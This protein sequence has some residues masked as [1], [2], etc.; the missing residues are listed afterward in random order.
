MNPL[1]VIVRNL[2]RRLWR[3]VRDESPTERSRRWHGKAVHIMDGAIASLDCR[4]EGDNVLHPGAGLSNV[5]LGRRTYVAGGALIRDTTIGR[6][7]SIG[8]HVSIVLGRH[9]VDRNVSTYPAFFSLDDRGCMCSFVE[10]TRFEEIRGVRI[11][12]DVWVGARALIIDGCSIGDGAVIAAGAVVTKDVAPYAVVGGVPARILRMRFPEHL[13]KKLLALKWW[14]KDEDWI[15]QHAA[16]F[17]DVEGLLD[18]A[19]SATQPREALP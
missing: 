14:D 18:V 15:R 13:V 3:A 1:T 10:S 11:G 4:F 9:K 2:C 8:P 7:C 12:N 6:Y 19:A 17:D 16:A 5:S